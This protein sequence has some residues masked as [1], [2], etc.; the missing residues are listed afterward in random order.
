MNKNIE[1]KIEELEEV[2]KYQIKNIIEVEERIKV[3]EKEVEQLKNN[4]PKEGRELIAGVEYISIIEEGSTQVE[5]FEWQDML[6][7]KYILKL[8]G[9]AELYELIVPTH[10]RQPVI[11]DCIKHYVI[12]KSIKTW[13]YIVN[14]DENE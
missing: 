12:G 5:K 1:K 6:W 14:N 7:K 8:K 2:V 9:T 3:L 10:K 11:G 13:K 4:R